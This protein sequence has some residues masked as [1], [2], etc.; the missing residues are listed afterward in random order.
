MNIKLIEGYG[1][2]VQPMSYS[3]AILFV[4]INGYERGNIEIF[5]NVVDYAKYE[6]DVVTKGVVEFNLNQLLR[7]SKFADEDVINFIERDVAFNRKPW[8]FT[9]A[10]FS[11]DPK[12][13]LSVKTDVIKET[14]LIEL[15]EE[16]E[17]TNYTIQ[18]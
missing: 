9:I 6:L 13:K 5:V 10:K 7:A 3:R 2:F 12:G 11:V 18:I 15:V 16:I 8:G 1:K 4:P 17:E 14:L